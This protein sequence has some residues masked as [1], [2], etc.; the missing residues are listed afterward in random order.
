MRNAGLLARARNGRERGMKGMCG[1]VRRG[2]EEEGGGLLICLFSVVGERVALGV[3][4]SRRGGVPCVC[5]V[6]H[7]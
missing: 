7:G 6:R 4:F 1:L 3:A 5:F 2:R